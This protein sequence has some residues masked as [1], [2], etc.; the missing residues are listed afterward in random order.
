M[1]SHSTESYPAE[2]E[3]HQFSRSFQNFSH[4]VLNSKHRYR[5]FW[6]ALANQV[7]STFLIKWPFHPVMSWEVSLI[8]RHWNYMY[9]TSSNFSETICM[10]LISDFFLQFFQFSQ[11]IVL[12]FVQ[13]FNLNKSENSFEHLLK[14]M[15][16]L[17]LM[18]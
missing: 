2:R 18:A 7:S 17:L 1:Y 16:W 11:L 13:V 5:D 10:H 3:F 8:S 12:N 15:M 6:H 4:M 14:N 9:F